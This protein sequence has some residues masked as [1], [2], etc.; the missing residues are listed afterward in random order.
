M[1]FGEEPSV[2][3]S[4]QEGGWSRLGDPDNV[5][6]QP[7]AHDRSVSPEGP[8]DHSVKPRVVYRRDLI[9]MRQGFLYLVAILVG[10]PRS[11]LTWRLSNS[12]DSS[13][14]AGG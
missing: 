11:V 12:M 5:E 4:R 3:E 7:G 10:A 13:F 9:P 1:V 14:C 2:D 6:A 8:I